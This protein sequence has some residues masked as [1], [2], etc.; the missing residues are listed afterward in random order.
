MS[1]S[2]YSIESIGEHGGSRDKLNG[3]FSYASAENS[4][5]PMDML[6]TSKQPGTAIHP[7]SHSSNKEFRENTES[8]LRGYSM[9]VDKD[10]SAELQ[11]KVD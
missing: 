1:E 11:S 8:I 5:F 7:Q 10:V 3:L 6:E 2:H 9:Y 4:C